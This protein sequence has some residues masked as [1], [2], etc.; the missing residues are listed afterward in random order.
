MKITLDA[1]DLRPLIA[2]VVTQTLERI[3][4]D[5]ARFAGRLAFSEAEAAAALGVE[6][7]VLRDCRLRGEIFARKIGKSYRYTVGSLR[8]FV[9]GGA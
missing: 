8:A 6:R 5:R 9:E 1:D 3:D 2:K 7:H 4:S